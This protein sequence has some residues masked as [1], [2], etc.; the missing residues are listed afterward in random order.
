MIDFPFYRSDP[1]HSTELEDYE[2]AM[3]DDERREMLRLFGYDDNH[4]GEAKRLFTED[5]PIPE[6]RKSTNWGKVGAI[7]TLIGIFVAI[8]LSFFNCFFQHF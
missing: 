7:F 1:W 5:L 2:N 6:I 4:R 3:N 8:A